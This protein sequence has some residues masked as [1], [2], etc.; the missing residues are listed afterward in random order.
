MTDK[1]KP[2]PDEIELRSD[3]WERF[4][5]AVDAAV[6]TPPRHRERSLS[7]TQSVV[8][9]NLEANNLIDAL[10]DLS[11]EISKRPMKLS[12]SPLDFGDLSTELVRVEFD[13][14]AASAGELSIRFNPSDRLCSLLAAVRAGNID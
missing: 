3:G 9:L 2:N 13:P 4:E 11:A 6:R 7:D 1:P 5:K 8:R 12:V 14:S 10:N